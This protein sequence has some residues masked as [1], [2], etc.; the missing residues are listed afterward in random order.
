[1]FRDKG[2][3]VLRRA[4]DAERLALELDRALED[5]HG[6]GFS[7][8]VG[9]GAIR[10]RYVPMTCERTPYSL[11]L[12]AEL[13]PIARELLGAPVLP[14]RAKGV[15]YAGSSPWH[16]DSALELPTVGFAAYLE[17]LDGARGALRVV[18]G[19]HVDSSLD[20]SNEQVVETE[21]GDV[22]AFD[23]RILHASHGGRLRRQWRTDFVVH[24]RSEAEEALARDWF[25]RTHPPDWDGGYDVD[26]Y[27]SYGPSWQS[28][29]LPGIDRLRDLGVYDL[30]AREEAFARSR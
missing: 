28:S 9:D 4:F 10:G 16:R 8:S 30:A 13:L 22:I 7:A 29:G 18:P 26:R 14:T 21:P 24:P 12:V 25:A 2:W 23:E 11:A 1:M 27:P 17:P 5:S 20:A 6:G 3:V 15:L 19:S